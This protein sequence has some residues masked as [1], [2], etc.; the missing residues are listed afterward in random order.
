M[1]L[2]NRSNPPR[3]ALH[4]Q[5]QGRRMR[6]SGYTLV[7]LLMALSLAAV[8]LAGLGGVTSMALSTYAAV[9]EKEALLVEA[10]FAMDQMVRTASLS[11]QI[12]LPLHDKA[13]SDWPENIREQTVP[14]SPPI[15]SSTLATAVLA[16][17]VPTAQ[18]LDGDGFPDAD[19]DRDG[20]IDE[21]LPDDADYGFSSGIYLIDDGGDGQVDEDSFGYTGDDDEYFLVGQED[22]I[23]GADD[24]ADYNVDEDPPADNN[25][26]GCPGRCGVDDDGDGQVDEGS[27]ADDDEDGSED[28][29]WLNPVVFH[30]TGDVLVQRTPV[31]W[32]ETG[33]SGVTGRDFVVHPIAE[34]V[35][36][37]RVERMPVLLGDPESVEL[38][39]ELTGPDSGE[40]VQ[41]ETRVRIGGGL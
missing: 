1:I 19:D 2:T 33:A 6:H 27:S 17:T 10:R 23:N 29:D 18:D 7:E 15:G 37:F 3:K 13:L 8:V 26:D 12:L 32:D 35:T 38:L 36:R 24:D 41:V 28:E 14:A 11:R 34:H 20:L 30:L 4:G 5:R 16:V 9:S 25:G 39:L 40:V 31:P 21:D 22:P